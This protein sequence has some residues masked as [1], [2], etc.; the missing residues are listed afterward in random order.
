MGKTIYLTDE[1]ISVLQPQLDNL[2]DDEEIELNKKEK[3]FHLLLK[4]IER[5]IS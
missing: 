4:S 3:G 2:I 5:K 1:E